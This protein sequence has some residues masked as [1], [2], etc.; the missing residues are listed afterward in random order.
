MNRQILSTV[1][2]S[3]YLYLAAC[4]WIVA[5]VTCFTHFTGVAFCVGG[6]DA[7]ST[8]RVTV[9]T[10]MITGACWNNGL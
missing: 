8:L 10:G 6:A 9:P 2:S 7:L 1:L 4:Y 5:P 3:V